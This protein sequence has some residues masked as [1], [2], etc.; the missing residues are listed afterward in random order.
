[1]RASHPL[2]PVPLALVVLAW[3]CAPAE[4]APFAFTRVQPDL[5]GAGGALVNAWADVDGDGD[6]DLFVGF[7]GNVPNRLYRNDGGVFT[8]VARAAG[9]ADLLRTRSGAWGDM[10]GDGDPD[11]ALGFAREGGP[12]TRLYRNDAGVFTDV[13]RAAGVAVAA[14]ATRQFAWVDVDGDGDLD[15]FTAFRD[16]PNR[17]WRNDGGRF[18]DIA[19]SVGLADGRRTV[20]AVWLDY[21]ADGDLDLYTAN[22]DGDANGLFR[23]DGGG[24][25]DVAEAAGVAWGGRAPGVEENGTVR[26]CAADVDGDGDLD[27]FNANYGPNGLF[28][29]DGDGT[30]RD[31]SEGVGIAIDGRYDSCAFADADDDGDLDL[32]VNGTITAGVQYRDYLFRAHGGSYV[33]ATPPA[34]LALHADHGVQWADYDG[35]GDMD[36]ALAGAEPDSGMHFLLRN[37]MDPAAARPA[38][39][40]LVVDG[41]GRATRAGAEVRLYDGAGRL[42]G[43]RLVDTGSGYNSQSVLPVHFAVPEGG[44][45]TVEV[46]WPAAG[47]RITARRDVRREELGGRPLVV[48]V[49]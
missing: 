6:A 13:T 16:A 27:L 1:M 22:M 20:G 4:P 25:T 28:L 30:F 31:I 10:D 3:G 40:V 18:T 26:P 15:L 9:L 5:F 21:D 33:D 42:L 47:R 32:F 49:P 29:N 35:D 17:L 11:L 37:D 12:V 36:L 48:E 24:F 23:N 39:E 8:D 7:N 45:F 2:L 43:T 46:T 19:S 34:L 38:L 44:R 14:G 41:D